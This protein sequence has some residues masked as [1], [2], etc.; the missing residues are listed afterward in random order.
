M[1]SNSY[2]FLLIKFGELIFCGS[3]L[4]KT[5]QPEGEIMSDLCTNDGARRL[6][7]KI[8][9]YWRKQGFDIKVEM[10]DEGFVTTMRS[11]RTD[12]RSDMV[13]GMPR[14]AATA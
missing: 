2:R 4:R 9:H 6:A 5:L 8:E 1:G 14:Q 11:G 13:N 12:V 3:Q 7:A 10:R